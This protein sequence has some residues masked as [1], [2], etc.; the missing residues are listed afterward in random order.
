MSHNSL[1]S[2]ALESTRRLEWSLHPAEE[3]D[4]GTKDDT[5]D[6][7]PGNI[8]RVARLMALAIHFEGMLRRG[9]VPDYTTVARLGHVTR[10]RISQIMDLLYLAPDIQEEVLLLPRT[11]N[12]RDPI[13]E[14]EVRP[15][16]RL[17]DWEQQRAAWRRLLQ[18]RCGL[19]G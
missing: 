17:L 6:V 8:P 19:S 5:P 4:P 9:D 1:A 11:Q 10:A 7:E 12:G 18:C 3:E 13:T 16:V 15:I 2:G 14:H